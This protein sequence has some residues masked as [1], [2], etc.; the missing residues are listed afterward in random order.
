MVGGPIVGLGWTALRLAGALGT[1]EGQTDPSQKARVLAEGIG[2]GMLATPIG[3]GVGALG[4]ILFITFFVTWLVKRP[5]KP[6][7][8]SASES[9]SQD[10][11]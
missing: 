5:A 10:P 6:T 4:M 3:L 1:V 8:G 11:G 7:G 2:D 9:A